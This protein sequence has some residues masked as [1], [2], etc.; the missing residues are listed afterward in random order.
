M[1]PI[2]ES[3]VKKLNLQPHPEGGYFRETFRSDQKV[4]LN[5]SEYSSG[6]SIYYLLRSYQ[7]TN[8]YSAWH[9]LNELDETWYYLDGANLTIYWITAKGD[10]KT[11]IL[12]KGEGATYQVN[13]P[14]NCWF[15]AYVDNPNPEGYCLVACAVFPGFDF[16]N[17][18]LAKR[19]ELLT[20]Y[21]QHA[22]L[23]SKLSR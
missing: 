21:P 23:I 2:I 9:K 7:T 16:K 10:L 8:D 22:D 1:S 4:I 6:T 14:R 20:L 13:I 11:Q 15:A 19:Q 3:L 5:D 18:E 17:F 12:G